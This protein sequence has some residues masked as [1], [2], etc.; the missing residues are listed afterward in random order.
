MKSLQDLIIERNETGK[1]A[2][3]LKSAFGNLQL[4]TRVLC[5]KC[6]GPKA[7]VEIVDPAGDGNWMC[8]M[9][10]FSLA[11]EVDKAIW[12]AKLAD[13]VTWESGRGTEVKSRR[14]TLLDRNRWTIMP[15]SPLTQQN[16][17]QWMI[18]LKNLHRLTLDNVDPKNVTWPEPPSLE[19][20]NA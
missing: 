15:D 11:R 12:A 3:K 10:M 1:N 6:N 14:S 2:R 8:T 7:P 17:A 20:S 18:Y 9:C 5:P 19:Y 16:Q 13:T 4:E